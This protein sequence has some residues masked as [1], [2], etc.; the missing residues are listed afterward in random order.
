MERRLR[1]QGVLSRAL[2]SE[3]R[4]RLVSLFYFEGQY[5][6]IH[7]RPEKFF[8][9]ALENIFLEDSA[10]KDNR[11]DAYQLYRIAEPYFSPTAGYSS[12][13][14]GN[15]P[16]PASKSDPRNLI[17][18]LRQ[19]GWFAGVSVS[20]SHFHDFQKVTSHATAGYGMRV[21]MDAA[22]DYFAW[23]PQVEYHLPAGMQW[24]FDF[25]SKVLF[26]Q[27]QGHAAI[28]AETIAQ[29]NYLIS[30]RWLG[31]MGVDH[32][33]THLSNSGPFALGGTADAWSVDVT[34][35]LCYFIEDHLSVTASLFHSQ[36]SNAQ[37][38]Y[39]PAYVR[40]NQFNLGLSYHFL[41]GLEA[42]GI[43]APSSL[44]PCHR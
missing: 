37:V 29:A 9:Q 31:Q 7:D 43:V 36:S 39:G 25:T 18:V 8:W 1:E 13:G 30:D 27:K 14:R 33:R 3:A 16:V 41:G 24:Q 32:Q 21:G 2:S 17:G 34:A 22:D 28:D 6:Q 20:A 10:L 4:H 42:P 23:G 5:S 44:L 19:R 38:S 12:I 11:L 35:S 40:D 26:P 15:L